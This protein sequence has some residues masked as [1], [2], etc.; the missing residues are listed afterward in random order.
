LLRSVV[1]LS[2]KGSA[3]LMHLAID[4]EWVVERRASLLLD[5]GDPQGAMKVLRNTRFQLVGPSPL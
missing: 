5:S 4:D 1:K 3:G 2:M